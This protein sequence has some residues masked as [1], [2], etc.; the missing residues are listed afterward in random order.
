MNIAVIVPC[1]NEA[2]RLPV[3]LFKKFIEEH[4]AFYFIFAN[5]G[6]TDKTED[7]LNE[8]CALRHDRS[9]CFSLDRNSGKAEAVRQGVLRAISRGA[10][11]VCYWDADLATPLD[12]LP[13][14]KDHME[15]HPELDILLGARVKLLGRDIQRNAVRHY[16][17]RLFATVAACVLK[18]A[19][20]DTQCGAKM[21]RIN[22]RTQNIFDQKFKSKWIFDVELI[23]RYLEKGK[24]ASD[25]YKE[26]ICEW[27]LPVWR[28]V[29]GSKVKPGDFV[30][31]FVD[32]VKI[33][34]AYDR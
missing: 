15:K 34:R 1:Y 9:E 26:R 21:F 6:S 31:A 11:A 25:D 29:A 20:Y 8:L 28:D 5:D 17:G 22:E 24:K 13:D 14:F 10:E 3:E 30:T 32:L 12:V 16:L 4:H 2:E 23:A 18:L 27:P 19:V 33:A 7:V